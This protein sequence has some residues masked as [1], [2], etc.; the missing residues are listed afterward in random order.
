MFDDDRPIFP[1][2]VTIAAVGASFP[3]T[4][5]HS[6]PPTGAIQEILIVKVTVR[7][8]GDTEMYSMDSM[9]FTGTGIQGWRVDKANVE[10]SKAEGSAGALD[11]TGFAADVHLEY[12]LV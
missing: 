3:A 8:A 2:I 4:T 7:N 11:W 9:H 1:A 12:T 10:S 5:A 6:L